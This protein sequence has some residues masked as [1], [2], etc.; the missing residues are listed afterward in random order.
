M[1]PGSAKECERKNLHTLKWTPMLGVGVPMDSWM[2]REWLQGSKPNG[3]KSSLY[4][5]KNIET[6]MSKMGSHH[7]FGHLKHKLWPKERSGVK[8]PIWLPTTKS[9]KS[10]RFPCVQ[11]AF[12][13][14]LESSRQGLHFSLD[15]ILIGG[16]HTKLWAPKSR[17][18]QLWQFRD[19]RLG[20]PGQKAIWMWT[21][22][23]GIEYNIRG[24]VVASPKS[25]LWWIL[26]VWVA[27]GSSRPQKCS[28]YA[29]T[30]LCWFC[31]GPYE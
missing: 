5:W 15:F 19:S 17:K 16:L 10:T 3:S 30:T 31:V 29:L 9:R 12:H 4:H 21:S 25:K 26:W 18:S 2:F 8:L 27:R 13:I 14:L 20:V 11:V 28:N 1:P 6:K 24:K 7:P 23:R 22:W